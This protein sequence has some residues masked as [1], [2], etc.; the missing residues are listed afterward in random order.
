M[1]R[2]IRPHYDPRL[3]RPSPSKPDVPSAAGS[4][5]P[6]GSAGDRGF[7]LLPFAVVASVLGIILVF[8]YLEAPSSGP[9]SFPDGD[10]LQVH[11][12]NG[13]RNDVVEVVLQ[14]NATSEHP[15]KINVGG[16]EVPLSLRNAE[17]LIGRRLR[18]YRQFEQDGRR[19][20]VTSYEVVDESD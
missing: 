4:G 11:D 7:S 19:F 13:R 8:G 12:D 17:H 18:L 14:E 20:D 2:R 1:V 16:R 5:P 10:V 3:R 15:Y 6:S 9:E